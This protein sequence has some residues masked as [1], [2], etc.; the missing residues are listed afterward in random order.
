MYG[1]PILVRRISFKKMFH[2]GAGY[3]TKESVV[4]TDLAEGTNSK[5][6]H[7]GVQMMTSENLGPTLRD[8]II[9]ELWIEYKRLRNIIITSEQLLVM[10]Y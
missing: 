5:G 7:F 10:M 6:V 1:L 9:K 2:G 3:S 8:Y 4:L